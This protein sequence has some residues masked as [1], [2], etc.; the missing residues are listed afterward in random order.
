MSLS[1]DRRSVLAMAALP[2]RGLGRAPQDVPELPEPDLSEARVLGEV[3]GLR[4]HRRGG[5]RIAAERAGEKTIVHNYGHGGAGVTLSWGCAEEAASLL[6][7]TVPPPAAVAVLGAGAVGLATA[8]VLQERGYRVRV[9]AKDFP[10]H[11]TSNLAGAEWLPV[12]VATGDDDAS[13]ARFTRIVRAS[14]RRFRALVGDTWGVYQ[15]PHYEVGHA[16]RLLADV[17]EDLVAAPEV[18]AKLP[19]AHSKRPGE[20]FTTMLIEPPTYLAELVRSVLLAGGVMQAR[21]FAEPAEVV[22][23]PEAAVVNCLGLGAGS[24]FDDDAV[25]PVRGQLVHVFPQQLPYLLSHEGGY[26]FPRR[27]CMVLGGTYEVGVAEASPD[28]RACA[29]ILAGHRR[30]FGG[31]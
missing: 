25:Q 23:L 24:V 30:F 14:W 7:E 15:R 29:D 17:P 28:R 26:L 6:G 5:I 22:T 16:R 4:P 1:L 3:A 11:T 12:G 8:R 2:L 13:R 9:L 19:F 27:D 10:P 31:A 20:R 18:L 21:T